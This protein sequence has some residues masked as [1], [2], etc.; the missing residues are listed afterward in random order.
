MAVSISELSPAALAMLSVDELSA[1]SLKDISHYFRQHKQ[2][3]LGVIYSYTSKIDGR[4][5]IGQTT[6]PYHRDYCHRACLKPESKRR[7]SNSPIS[8]AFRTDGFDTF[9]HNVLQVCWSSDWGTLRRN[10]DHCEEHHIKMY[11][12]VNPE[13]GFN[14][15][16]GG[17][18]TLTG[19]SSYN[20]RPVQQYSLSGE[21]IARYES[22]A[23]AARSTKC[24]CTGIR[25][26]CNHAK[27]SVSSGGFLWTYVDAD[28]IPGSTTIH[29][30]G[31]VHRYSLEGDYID[32]FQ[33][34]TDAARAVNGDRTRIQR[35]A[36]SSPTYTAYGFRWSK[37]KHEKL[38]GVAFKH[39]VEVHCYGAD[40]V[41]ICSYGSLSNATKG[42]NKSGS[43]HL[44]RCLREPWRK[45][46]G[47]YWRKERLDRIEVPVK[48]RRGHG[49]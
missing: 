43:S 46:G 28:L 21:F 34:Y 24:R 8:N 33:R 11:D 16:I 3:H 20:A 10:L 15:R 9:E 42:V 49:E 38:S 18:T 26:A 48:E 29:T 30:R 6:S 39:N 17:P 27:G 7:E 13:K 4:K 37:E 40:G 45:A 47:F 36:F 2:A 44:I 19:G 32:T 22:T 41:F 14:V 1:V 35:R 12:T 31:I 23:D 25:Q 5:Y